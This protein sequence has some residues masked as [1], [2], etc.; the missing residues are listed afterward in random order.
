MNRKRYCLGDCDFKS[1]Y[2][3]QAGK[4]FDD[5]QVF[6][7]Y[8]YQRGYGLGSLFKRFG[9]PL[10]KFIG[11]HLL[12][13]G[14]AIG[15]DMLMNNSVDK[16]TIK[17]KLKLGAKEAAKEALTKALDKV[18]QSGSGRKRKRRSSKKVQKNQGR[19]KVYKRRK[20]KALDIFSHG[21]PSSF[22]GSRHKV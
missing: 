21:I 11:R 20:R 10:A 19:K 22:I 18:N 14:L 6:R 15:G 9:I 5:I 4:G 8:P 7:G 2:L 16:A 12:H 17:K 3:N 1:Y 13:T